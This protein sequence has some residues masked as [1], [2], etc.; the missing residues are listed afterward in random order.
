MTDWRHH[1]EC[2]DEDPEMFFPIGTTGPALLQQEEAKAVC[3]RCPVT[4]ECL[5]W[6]LEIGQDSG[7]W[8][9][10]TEVERRNMKRRNARR[11]APQPSS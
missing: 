6:A 10:T 9:G 2:L 8:G 7:V 4:G 11:R 1:A 5:A 3:R